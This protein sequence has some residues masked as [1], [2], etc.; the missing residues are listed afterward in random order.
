M[1]R[2]ALFSGAEWSWGVAALMFALV[3]LALRL[4]APDMFWRVVQPVFELSDATTNQMHGFFAS[5]GDAATLAV[6]N[7][8]LEEEN[9]A[10][11]A[12]NRTLEERVRNLGSESRTTG[13][14]RATVVARPPQSPYDTLVVVAGERAGVRLGM[15]AFTPPVGVAP[16]GGI[17]IGIVSAVQGDFSRVTLFSSS[18]TLSA[19]WVGPQ[20]LALTLRGVGGGA[21]SA[22]VARTADIAVG[23]AVSLP[24]PGPVVIG[25]VVRIDNDPTMPGVTLRIQSAFNLFSTTVVELRPTLP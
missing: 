7:E 18:G 14:I 24:G 11:A 15:E 12:E 3:A 23:D 20:S 9:A 25:S 16:T 17:P 10:L 4:V 5:F 8:K 6:R 22:I 13:A 2:N 21:F 1:K 19:G